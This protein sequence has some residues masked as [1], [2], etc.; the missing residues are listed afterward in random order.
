MIGRWNGGVNVFNTTTI[1]NIS[2]KFIVPTMVAFGVIIGANMFAG[3]NVSEFYIYPLDLIV[4][5][6]K[7]L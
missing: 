3:H 7:F 2:L 5:R 1:M 4:Y 6:C